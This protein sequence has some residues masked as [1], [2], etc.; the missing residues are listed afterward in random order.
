MAAARAA[1]IVRREL[2]ALAVDGSRL[3]TR[4]QA[5]P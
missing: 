2:K 4:L 5:T 3:S 1:G